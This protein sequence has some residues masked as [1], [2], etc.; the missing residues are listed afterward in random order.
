MAQAPTAI[1][2]VLVMTQVVCDRSSRML[3]GM[4]GCGVRRDAGS[5]S[6]LERSVR[7]LHL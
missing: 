1:R 2:C 7:P 5:R 6:H 4:N 3:G